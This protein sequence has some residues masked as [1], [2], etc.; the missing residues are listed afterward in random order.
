RSEPLQE[1][2]IYLL[3]SDGLSGAISDDDILFAVLEAEDL[4]NGC[5]LLVTLANEAGGK[6]NVSVVLVAITADDAGDATAA[7][8]DA[9]DPTLDDA[10]SVDATLDDDD[11]AAMAAD[12]APGGTVEM[13]ALDDVLVAAG[14]TT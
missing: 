9:L 4:E 7:D 6:D 11:A 1:G 5:E 13:V 8:G 3:C 12:A 10:V 14:G 2:D